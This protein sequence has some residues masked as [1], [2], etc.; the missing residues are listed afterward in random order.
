MAS[1]SRLT[2]LQHVIKENNAIIE[3]RAT[4]LNV[5]IPPLQDGLPSKLHD[6]LTTFKAL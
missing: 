1:V 2:E 3:Q 5:Q 4:A 6:D